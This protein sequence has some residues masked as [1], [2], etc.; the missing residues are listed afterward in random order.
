MADFGTALRALK[1]GRYVRREDWRLNGNEQFLFFV[2]GS[3]FR[4]TREPYRSMFPLGTPID[5]SPHFDLWT[6]DGRVVPY[7]F[8]HD[9]VVAED[10]EIITETENEVA[11]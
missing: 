1:R 6:N 11:E 5:Y 9:D 8:P 2:R 4:V 3:Q 7:T 10:W